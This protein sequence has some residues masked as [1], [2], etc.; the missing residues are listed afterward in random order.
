VF[1]T[2]IPCTKCEGVGHF[3]KEG[4]ATCATCDGRGEVQEARKS[5]FGNF[6]QVRACERCNGE[7]KI[8]NKLC[9]SCS[10]NGRKLAEK[11]VQIAIAPG[12]Q[13][14]Q[15]IKISSAG[16]VGERGAGAGD[17]YVHIKIKPH[18]TFVRKGDELIMKKEV[19]L[20]DV[21]LE[22]ELHITTIS[23]E[24]K[25]VEIPEGFN[26]RHPVK[27]TGAGMPRLGTQSYGDLYVTL[28]VTTPKKLSTKAKKILEELK[29]EVEGKR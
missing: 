8:P 19:S 7:G 25:T 20:T 2:F 17:L 18:K 27:I 22:K 3:E 28:D 13:D 1:K 23:G 26:L 4:H 9:E 15:F 24:K 29:R 12:V 5:F 10:G 16:E 11:S 21:L 6:T 14:N